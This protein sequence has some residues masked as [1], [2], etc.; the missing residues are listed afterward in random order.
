MQAPHALTAPP[1]GAHAL[2]TQM[3]LAHAVWL[4]ALHCTHAP[5]ASHTCV[6]VSRVQSALPVQGPHACVAEQTGADAEQSIAARHAT[7]V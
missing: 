1:V 4:D 2:P 5:L 7:H 3:P 6:P